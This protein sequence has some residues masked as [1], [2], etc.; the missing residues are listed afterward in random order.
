MD[1]S[2]ISYIWDDKLIECCDRLPAVLGRASMVHS[3]I[4]TYNLLD[5]IKVVRSKPASYQDLKLFHTETYIEHVKSFTDVDEDY[6]PTK[7][8]EEYGF[9]YD[10]TPVSDMYDIISNI[11]GASITAAECLLRGIADVSIN[12]CGGWHHAHKSKAE[13]FCY[14]NDIVIAIEK[15]RKKFSKVLYIDL[16]VHHGNGVQDAY[17]SNESVFTLSFHKYEPGFYPGTGAVTDISS[18][19]QGYSCNFPLHASYCDKTFVHAFNNIIAEVYSHFKPDVIVVQCGADALSLDPHGGAGLTIKGYCTCVYKILQTKKPTLLLGG[20]GYNHA[21]AAKLW[22]AITA[23]AADVT[24]DENIPEHTYWPEYGPGYTLKVEPLLAKDL[25]T[26]Q[27]IEH[28]TA[29]I[30]EN[31]NK[32]LGEYR[33][34]AVLPRKRKLDW[35]NNSK[36]NDSKNDDP[37]NKTLDTSDVYEFNE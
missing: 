31:L 34:N 27:Y 33:L 23:H 16:D 32:Y 17:D 24:L 2:K 4:V 3:L 15:L 14:V 28:I 29:I 36:W 20:G 35:G 26:T 1:K 13:G 22:T 12:W 19:A 25:N 5:Q 18:K 8:D 11:A 10:C 30:K 9:G 7:K 37:E 21:N 6:M